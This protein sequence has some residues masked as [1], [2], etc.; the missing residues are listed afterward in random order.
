[1]QVGSFNSYVCC[2]KDCKFIKTSTSHM[3]PNH[4]AA[5]QI[6]KLVANFIY[7]RAKKQKRDLLLI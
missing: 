6:G 5:V 2:S 4:C 7:S 1:M 3:I